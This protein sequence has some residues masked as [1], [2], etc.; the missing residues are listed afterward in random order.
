M[1][2]APIPEIDRLPGTVARTPEP[3]SR[4][5]AAF[6][7][8]FSFP[9]LLGAFLVL[10]SFLIQR[11]LRLDPDT[12]WHIKYGQGILHTGHWPAGD[13]YSFTAHGVVSMAYEWVGEIVMAIAYQLGHLRGLDLLLIMLTSM[14]L[15]LL[16][17]FAHLR[18]RNSK[19]AFLGT[20][21]ALPLAMLCLTMR[22]QLL[23]FIFLLIVLICLERY[24]L[25][26]Q[27]SLW[28]LP[29]LF[30][31]WVNTH[32]TFAL[33]LFILAVYWVSGLKD[34]SLGGL[35]SERWN[36]KQ[37]IH[38]ALV[39]LASVAVLPI[40][41]Y[42]SG[43]AAYPLNIAFF[44]PVNIANIQEW[45]P[46]PSSYW[47][48][49]LLFIL[50]LAFIVAPV[51]LRLTYRL[52]E[53]ALFVF[54]AYATLVHGRFVFLFAILL[55]PLVASIFARWVPKYDRA[56]DKYVLN[57]LLIAGTLLLMLR[58]FPSEARLK[59]KVA[60]IYPAHAVEYL[61]DHFIP[62]PMFNS[63]GFGGYL[64]WSMGPQH[65][66]FIDGR[67]GLYEETGT[68]LDYVRINDLKSNTLAI[69]QSYGIKSCL[70]NRYTS[71][72]TLLAT[73][74]GW[75][76]VY[77]DKVSEIFVRQPHSRGGGS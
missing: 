29:P 20:I 72:A 4:L 5:R 73:T 43:L 41:P 59:Q 26:R 27:R 11:A 51:I 48:T 35:R 22:P 9:V 53:L 56:A 77:Q 42:G 62:G 52:E 57:A 39:F 16:Y 47:Q 17:Y 44:Q 46:L 23:G 76:Q 60:G 75:R 10:M 71:L 64:L 13:I 3:S 74:A 14:F 65:K 45:N 6:E 55:A 21:L 25:G 32:G 24:R 12:W 40:T 67:A 61:R 37:R 1:S 7:K 49:K 54:A 30:L 34:F 63:Y 70:I 36:P 66:V 58:Y 19:A 33:G 68:L 50:V 15:L 38:L 2:L 69:L 8:C 31:A 18:C 28:L